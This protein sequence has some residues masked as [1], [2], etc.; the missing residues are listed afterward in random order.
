MTDDILLPRVLA[1]VE[2]VAGRDRTPADA[3]PDTPLADGFWLDSVETLDVIVAC[4]SDFGIVFD[5]AGDFGDE[6]FRTLGTLTDLVRRR[7]DA[8]MAP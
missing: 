7:L 2:R 6:T 5:A 4:E 1:I 8:R 3:G